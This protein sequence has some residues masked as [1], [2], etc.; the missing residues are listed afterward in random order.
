VDRGSKRGQPDRLFG[1][2]FALQALWWI[3]V[4]VLQH[5]PRRLPIPLR[6]DATADAVDVAVSDLSPT[7]W[8]ERACDL[9]GGADGFGRPVVRRLTSTVY[10]MSDHEVT[11]VEVSLSAAD[12]RDRAAAVRDWLLAAGVIVANPTPGTLADPSEFLAGPE[13]EARATDEDVNRALMNSGVDIVTARRVRLGR[14]PRAPSVPALWS[15]AC[16][17]A[18][19]GPAPALAAR[20]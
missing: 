15:A 13:A 17:G 2:G 11:L 14:E 6:L 20:R 8:R 4:I 5:E 19:H 18:V 1:A 7:H 10:G 16:L 12:A 9:N 3:A